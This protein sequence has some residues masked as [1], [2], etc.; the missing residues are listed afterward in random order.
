M[1]SSAYVNPPLATPSSPGAYSAIRS[2]NQYAVASRTLVVGDVDAVAQDA[3]A[4]AITVTLPSD[5][6]VPGILVGHS[7]EG[8][9]TGAGIVALA[10][11]SGASIPNQTLA[12]RVATGGTWFWR[13]IAANTYWIG[14]S[15]QP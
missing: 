15:L 4:T 6:A 1:G 7:G 8:N 13:K 5:S 2:I 11:G 3:Y 14:G 10:P 9:V 12:R